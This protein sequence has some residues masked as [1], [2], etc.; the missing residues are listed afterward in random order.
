MSDNYE[1]DFH[2]VGNGARSGE[3]ISAKIT[4]AGTAQTFVIDGGTSEAGKEVSEHISKHYG[5]SIVNHMVLTH[6][7]DDHSSGLRDIFINCDVRALWIHRPW[8]YAAQL[9]DK[10]QSNWT[11]DGLEKKLRECFPIVADLE[12]KA[13]DAGVPIYSPFEG[14]QIGPF[15]VTSPS[16]ELYLSLLPQMTRTPDPSQEAKMQGVLKKGWQIFADATK[17]AKEVVF[18]AFESWNVET[19]SDDGETGASN[20]SSVILYGAVDD[21][22][23][24]LTGDAG[25]VALTA[26]AD[27]CDVVGLPLQNFKLISIPHH[28]SRRNVGPTILDRLIGPR[29]NEN[30]K[31]KKGSAIVSAAKEDEHHPK[32]VVMNAFK[33]RGKFTGKTEGKIICSHHN[34]PTR[35]NWS[36]IDEIPIFNDVET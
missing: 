3:A 18:G 30:E 34:T 31:N 25:Q 9:V 4:I 27:Y 28:G 29:V 36:S 22:S 21:R 1:F 26:A 8:L 15:T 33:R 5:T 19:L 17:A 12:E 2:P 6:A 13:I 23:V 35:E 32:R 7:D 16:K 11:V 14:E 10:F 24:L 20:E